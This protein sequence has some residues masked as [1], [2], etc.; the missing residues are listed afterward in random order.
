MSIAVAKRLGLWLPRETIDF[1]SLETDGS[2]VI[3]P[4]YTGCAMLENKRVGL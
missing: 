4:Y 2:E 1:T 3:T